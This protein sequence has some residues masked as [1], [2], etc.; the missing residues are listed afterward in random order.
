MGNLYSSFGNGFVPYNIIIGPGYQVYLTGAGYDDTASRNAINAALNGFSLY[1]V[2]IPQDE[3]MYFGDHLEIDL[4]N[5]FHNDTAADIAYEVFEN[6]DTSAVSTSISGSTL[7]LDALNTISTAEITIRATIPSKESFVRFKVETFDPTLFAT[8]SES[9]E[10]G[11]L[12]SGWTLQTDGAGWQQSNTN[13][14]SGSH[15]A[16]H[17]DDDTDVAKEDWLWS[18][19]VHINGN[20]SLT[21]WQKSDYASYIDLHGIAVSTNLNRYYWLN[22][23][24]ATSDTW[25]QISYDLSSYDGKDIYI[26]FYYRGDYADRWY[27]DDV[28]V[29]T[30]TGINNNEGLVID[31]FQLEQNYP[32]PFNP[33]TEIK[34]NLKNQSE[35]KLAVMNSKGEVV[36]HLVDGKLDRGIHQVNF[37]AEQ[38]NTGIYFYT[39]EVDGKSMT[40]KMLLL[41]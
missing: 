29:W 4:S 5:L 14:Y 18:R 41:K 10:G 35:V 31:N 17:A 21:F 34:F 1:P 32:N 39:L 12:P 7:N 19:A 33:S 25:E 38:L 8:L 16:Y 20:S 36:S 3:E 40:K 27:V 23:D 15:S 24:L 28:K 11:F 22:N 30:T 9:F 13:G 26:G 6:S 2:S 37:N